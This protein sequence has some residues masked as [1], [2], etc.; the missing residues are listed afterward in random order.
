MDRV[1]VGRLRGADVLLGE[2]IALDLDGL[3]GQ[4]RVEG[5]AIVGRRHGDGRDSGLRAGAEDPRRDLAA[6]RYEELSDLHRTANV[7]SE[8]PASVR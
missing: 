6:V 5:A 7:I 8:A 2:E 3:V 1:G 4:P